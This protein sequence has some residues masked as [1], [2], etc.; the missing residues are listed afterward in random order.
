MRRSLLALGI[1][2]STTI[3][4]SAVS[5]SP[6]VADTNTASISGSAV[7]AVGNQGV[8][9][10]QVELIGDVNVV[11]FGVGPKIIAVQQTDALG[12]YSFTG[13][14]ASDESGYQICFDTGQGSAN[15]F[16]GQC[17]NGHKWEDFINVSGPGFVDLPGDPIHLTDGQH[18]TGINALLTPWATVSGTI[19]DAQT[20]VRLAGAQLNF[21]DFNNFGPPPVNVTSDGNGDYSA[22]L[23]DG[24]QNETVCVVATGI[25]NGAP[26]G[27]FN[28]CYNNVAWPDGAPRPDG[29][30]FN[31]QGGFPTTINFALTPR[32][33]SA[34]IS[35][36]VRAGDT[37]ALLP[38]VT[39]TAFTLSK[40]AGGATIG[41][42]AA[43]TTTSSSGTYTLSVSANTKYDVCFGPDPSTESMYAAQCYS[44]V[45]WANKPLSR[46]GTT[47]MPA[48]ATAL[49]ATPGQAI[50][51]VNAVLSAGAISGKAS[52]AST[53]QA[54]A[55]VLVELFGTGST[56]I[57]AT[58]TKADGTYRF[59]GLIAVA[60]YRICFNGAS[61]IGGTSKTGYSAQCWKASA[62]SG[63]GAPS[64]TATPISVALGA[65]TT[66]VSAAL[67]PAGSA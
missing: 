16:E 31:A 51:N 8:Q 30:P 24:P 43:S 55:N 56:P 6:A 49:S 14:A 42:K 21:L 45:P 7:T 54:L 40:A 18:L 29:T 27:Y 13:L 12:H 20:G 34:T 23:L 33:P 53:H 50:T 4:L 2:A 36:L 5:M 10:V 38:G 60:G 65:T 52:Q 41:T 22:S 44:F 37:Y 57:G 1:A 58:L 63:T 62:W 9:G 3:A 15:V 46:K 48:K 64:A 66:G 35:G 61:G 17:Y 28:Q 25:T 67:S 59:S 32:T 26:G 11:P 47:G 19:T 39:V